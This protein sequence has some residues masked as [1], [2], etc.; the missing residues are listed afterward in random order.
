MNSEDRKAGVKAFS[1]RE[2]VDWPG[3]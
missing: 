2:K 3:R 1:K